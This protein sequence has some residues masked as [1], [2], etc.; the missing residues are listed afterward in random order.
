MGNEMDSASQNPDDGD[1]FSNPEVQG[2]KK[3]H[4]TFLIRKNP[5]S[6]GGVQR[7][8]SAIIKGLS[9]S[10]DI[11]KISWGGPEWGAP[12]YFPIFYYKSIYNISEL[13]HCDD[14]VTA[15]VG[16]RV[17][18]SSD[19][20]VVATVHGLDVIL[21]IPWYQ[22]KLSVAL[23]KIDRIICVSR[24]T[25]EQVIKRGVDPQKIRIIP[26]PAEGSVKK[27]N[28][29]EE[30][31]CRIEKL[32]GVNLRNKKVL[33][34]LGRLVRRKGF[35]HFITDIMPQLPDDYV[36]IVAGPIPRSPSWLKIF[37]PIIG[38]KTRR[39]LYLASGSDTIHE[40]LMRLSVD[41]PRTYYL[42]GISDELRNLLF[43]VSD[44]FIMPNRHVDGDME[45]FGIVALEASVR[46]VP[47]IASGI[48][49][50]TD[51]VINGENGYTVPEGEQ[52]TMARVILNLLDDRDRLQ[53]LRQRAIITAQKRFS[54]EYVSN[55]YKDTFNE[56]FC[57]KKSDAAGRVQ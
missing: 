29:D 6:V 22:Q 46:G 28:R 2:S 32:T 12:F 23:G 33:F 3:P 10:F 11:E 8:S 55:C 49:G 39:L 54:L 36:Y 16:A 30:L 13:I 44:L 24:A 34:S 15:L 37:G 56:L 52:M 26:C 41:N 17:H 1:N 53:G 40:N 9:D 38:E 7:L 27:I 4:V 43:A 21:P 57:Q 50:I 20:K 18:S 51:A 25:A 47:V 5:K 42:N 45:G 35:D 31:Y 19:K 14:A 48:E